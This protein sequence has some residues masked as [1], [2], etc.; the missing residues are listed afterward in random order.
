MISIA[1]YKT[2]PHHGQINS[3]IMYHTT[4][5][6]DKT[7]DKFQFLSATPTWLKEDCI[8]LSGTTQGVKA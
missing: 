7:L 5:R 4:T 2:P 1:D 3:I 8:Y 6:F